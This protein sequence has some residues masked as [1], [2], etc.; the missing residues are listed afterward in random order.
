MAEIALAERKPLVALTEFR[1]GDVQGDGYPAG[2]CGPCALFNLGRAF[3]LAEM[4]DSAI[5]TYERYLATPF[6][7]KPMEVDAFGLAGTHKRL[8]ELYEARGERQKAVSHYTQFV[9]LWKNADPDLQ[10]K[11]A[12]VKQRLARL[13]DV[14]RR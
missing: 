1:R 6:W 10:P 3:D 2:E 7:A 5:A 11:V 13:N 14:E 4:A 8:G 12:E 9:E